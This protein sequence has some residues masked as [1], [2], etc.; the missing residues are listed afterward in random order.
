VVSEVEPK[1]QE[2]AEANAKLAEANAVLA[3]VQEKVRRSL[4][5]V[6]SF[7]VGLGF[8]GPRRALPT[9][10]RHTHPNTPHT[11]TPPNP[12]NTTYQVA[13][14]NAQVAGLEAAFGAAV[15]EKES[16]IK[17]AARCAARLALANRLVA[18]LLSEGERWAA[19]VVELRGGYAALT[20]DMLLA[21]AAVSY[22]GVFTARFRAALAAEWVR[23]LA[24]RGVPMAR[25]VKGAREE[26][27]CCC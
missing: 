4:V 5:V 14:L 9:H 3:A 6:G 7:F 2:L 11:T 12:Q 21:A 1:R 8:V 19:T 15:E 18:A 10:P 25:D 22:A 13:A 20:G 24:E 23:F 16:A 26:G 17:E 27:G